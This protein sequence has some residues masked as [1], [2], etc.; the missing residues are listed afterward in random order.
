MLSVNGLRTPLTQEAQGAALRTADPLLLLLP[1]H[2]LDRHPFLQ[3]LLQDLLGPY[4]TVLHRRQGGEALL[5]FHLQHHG[6]VVA[7]AP[8]TYIPFSSFSGCALTM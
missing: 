6:R 2:E 1:A 4:S 3:A 5:L 7:L 8:S